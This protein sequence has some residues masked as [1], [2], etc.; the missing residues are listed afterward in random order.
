[1]QNHHYIPLSFALL[2]FLASSSSQLIPPPPIYPAGNTSIILDKPAVPQSFRVVPGGTFCFDRT[3]KAGTSR[4]YGLAYTPGATLISQS[5]VYETVEFYNETV[6]DQ[7]IPYNITKATNC[8]D[9]ATN[10]TYPCNITLTKTNTTYKTILRNRTVEQLIDLP[11]TSFSEKKLF[12]NINEK[13]FLNRIETIRTKEDEFKKYSEFSFTSGFFLPK[14]TKIRSCF[15]V[16]GWNSGEPASG[17]ISPLSGDDYETTVWWDS[18]YSYRRNITCTN[19]DDGV[20]LVVNG[21]NG[22]NIPY[23]GCGVNQVV[24]TYCSGSGTAL[25]YNNCTDYVV[26]NDTGQLPMEVEIGNGTSYNPAGV[27]QNAVRVYHSDSITPDVKDS[28]I[29]SDNATVNSGLVLK[30]QD[31]CMIGNC[32]YSDTDT[33]NPTFTTVTFSDTDIYT[34]NFFWKQNDSVNKYSLFMGLSSDTNNCFRLDS[35]GQSIPTGE[36]YQETNTNGDYWKSKFSSVGYTSWGMTTIRSDGSKVVH[37]YNGEKGQMIENTTQ[38]SYIIDNFFRGFDSAGY[39][40]TGWI[41]EVSIYNFSWTDTQINQTYQNAIGTSGYGDLGNQ[42]SKPIPPKFTT[43]TYSGNQI[44]ELYG[45]G[46]R[47]NMTN[48]TVNLSENGVYYALLRNK[49]QPKTIQSAIRFYLTVFGELML[50]IMLIYGLYNVI[51]EIAY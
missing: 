31:E 4:D 44:L 14:D 20:P 50:G 25:Y 7:R 10:T 42:E 45:D 5:F 19:M 49:E 32:L 27:Y 11:A 36:F 8:T 9:N 51:K 13:N 18:S 46:E 43:F 48:Q 1:M 6:I 24:W 12:K 37:F 29:N 21:S 33:A 16:A 26:A 39:Q 35:S 28:S 2:V 23:G 40:F 22:F 15:R 3:I 47:I 30:N 34:I 38:V 17:T 41:D